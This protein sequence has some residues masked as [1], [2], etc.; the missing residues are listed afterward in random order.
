MFELWAAVGARGDGVSARPSLA[1]H[2]P[3]GRAEQS[4]GGRIKMMMICGWCEDDMFGADM[5]M[6]GV[7]EDYMRVTGHHSC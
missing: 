5:M 2:S 7:Y 3:G 6:G 4:R 1:I